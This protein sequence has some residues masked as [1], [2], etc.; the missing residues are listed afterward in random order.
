MN[1]QTPVVAETIDR[2]LASNDLRKFIAD[3][4]EYSRD[5][6]AIVSAVIGELKAGI[7]ERRDNA[8]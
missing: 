2:L 3:M 5:M 1:G 7:R 8:P 6:D 4:T